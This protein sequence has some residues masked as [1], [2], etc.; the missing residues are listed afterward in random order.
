[1]KVDLY[2]LFRHFDFANFVYPIT[3]SVLKV[4]AESIGHEVRVSVCKE[5]HVNLST[6]ADIVGI[7]VYIRVRFC[8][9]GCKETTES[10][11]IIGNTMIIV[12]LSISH[13]G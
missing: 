11:I 1:M 13:C 8:S 3:L 6:D 7:S 9:T 2:H 10:S 5:K 4:W 12:M